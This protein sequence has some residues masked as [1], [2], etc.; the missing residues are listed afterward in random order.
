VAVSGK[1]YRVAYFPGDG[2]GPEVMGEACRVLHETARLYGFTVELLEGQIG[3]TALE[4][5]GKALPGETL[6]NAREAVAVLLGP[7]GG[8][9]PAPVTDLANP[10]QAVMK[11]RAWLGSYATIRP[12]RSFKALAES[13]PLRPDLAPFN[14]V[15]VY[16]HASG[17]LYG[18]P[19]GFENA[20]PERL[21]RNTKVY[22]AKE[23]ARVG[24]VAFKAASQRGG[25][26]VSVDMAR[27]LETGQ[28]WQ[29]EMTAVGEAHPGIALT[30]Q[31]ADNF[32]FNLV[33]H[34]GRFDVVVADS[35]LG[36][37]IG[38]TAAGLTG[39]YGMH[40]AAYVGGSTPIFQPSHGPALDIAGQAT[41][42]PIGAI[43][44]VAMML[45]LAVNEEQEEAARA[46]EAAVER[47]LNEG[48][49]VEEICPIGRT[50]SKTREVGEAVIAAV[51]AIASERPK[52][53]EFVA[54]EPDATERPPS[55]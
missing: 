28:L 39:S 16:D 15:L 48:M 42:N 18:M 21:A 33:T 22:T 52:P 30:H 38:M 2:I 37:L 53:V 54:A 32:M 19:R 24:E 26:V 44:A 4:A 1:T 35:T 43:R 51:R 11:L 10:K 34:P 50:S 55:R 40:P 17:L 12:I 36:E 49:L 20:G 41:A 6:T 5:T 45:D 46:I 47:V 8:P 29:E 3:Q 7:V 9:G 25:R 13:S 31:D 23:V 14:M 27:R